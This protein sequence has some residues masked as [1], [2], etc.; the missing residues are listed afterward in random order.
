[1]ALTNWRPPRWLPGSG[2]VIPEGFVAKTYKVIIYNDSMR[3]SV[4]NVFTGDIDINDP[5]LIDKQGWFI[6]KINNVT[7]YKNI[8]INQSAEIFC[9]IYQPSSCRLIIT[10]QKD[11]NPQIIIFDEVINDQVREKLVSLSYS[12]TQWG[13]FT[14][15]YQLITYAGQYMQG[16]CKPT[17]NYIEQRQSIIEVGLI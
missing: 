16:W 14:V 10:I 2:G 15:R 5:Y 9:N 13:L 3:T 17:T 4:V 8:G 11:Q 7:P 12:F 6:S 1:M